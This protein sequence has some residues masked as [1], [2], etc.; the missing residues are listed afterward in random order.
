MNLFRISPPS[1]APLLGFALLLCSPILCRADKPRPTGPDA[2]KRFPPLRLPPDFKATLFACDPF[3]EYP[4]A[5]AQGPRAGSLYVAVDY[6]TGLG[7]QVE[8]RDEIRLLEDTDGDG[9]ADKST[10]YASGFGSIQGLTSHDG[11]VYV[12]HAP[13]L[14][15]LRGNDRDGGADDRRDLFTGLGL[16]PEVDTV[17]LHNAN[18]LMMGYD[19]WLYLALGDHG[20]DVKR[21]EGDRLV[22][23]GGGILRCRA[24]GRD[25]HVFSTGLRNIYDVALNADL[26]VFVRDNENDGGDY[27]IRVCH[28][29][30]GADHGYPYLYYEWPDEALPPLA[31]LGLGSSAGGVCYLERQFPSEYQGNLFFCEWGRAVVRYASRPAGSAFGPLTQID[32]A[33][34]SDNDPYGFKPTDL[35]VDRDGALFVADWCDGQRP[36]RGRGRIYRITSSRAA[37]KD[38]PMAPPNDAQKP[39]KE[40]SVADLLAELDSESFSQ[41]MDAQTALEKRNCEHVFAALHGAF[42]QRRLSPR[43]RRHAVWIIARTADATAQDELFRIAANDAEAAVQVQAIRALAD[44]GD[45]VLAQHRLDAAPGDAEFAARLG[46]LADGKDPRVLREVVVALARLRWPDA[47]K[48]LRQHLPSEPD[49]AL[50]HAAMQA[51][52]RSGNWPSVADL[53][54]LPSDRPLRAIALRAVADQFDPDLV[55]GLV[56]RL[57]PEAEPARLQQYADLL[58]RVWQKPGTWIYWGFRPGPRPPGTVA[59][60]RT[61]K[62]EESLRGVLAADDVAVRL[63]VLRRMQRERIPVPLES[64]LAWLQDERDTGAVAAIL[65]SLGEHSPES[66]RAALAEVAADRRHAISNRLSALALLSQKL[67]DAAQQSLL[68]VSRGMEDG[69]VLAE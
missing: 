44:L 12:M 13:N 63:A 30:F 55:D 57:R 38:A 18:G 22:L 66:V 6:M 50:A 49:A 14:T 15:V 23:N 39:E 41:R 36:R 43:A 25:L 51:L 54:D 7:T 27:K 17:R 10:L 16:V 34:G 29:F 58:S 26:D 60:E 56:D 19:G 46:H 67:D 4:S 28:S 53:L 59:W 42:T 5:I 31:D 64:L 3:I 45:P 8:R 32:F 65:T 24:D 47:P 11:A 37:D 20:C 21:P 9:Y 48:W 52:R 33:A 61:A 68:A 62:I 1:L 69:P 2:E 35:V 40:T